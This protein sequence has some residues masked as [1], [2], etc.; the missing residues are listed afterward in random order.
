MDFAQ[1]F[2]LHLNEGLILDLSKELNILQRYFDEEHNGHYDFGE[3]RILIIGHNTNFDDGQLQVTG[4]VGFDIGGSYS[5]IRES[6]NFLYAE[7]RIKKYYDDIDS[8]IRQYMNAGY[9]GSYSNVF[10]YEII[11]NGSV[12]K[13]FGIFNTFDNVSLRYIGGFKSENGYYYNLIKVFR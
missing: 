9:D 8:S 12:D 7:I 5:I 6:S 11:A 10:T 1:V 2:C 13:N 4:A 3:I